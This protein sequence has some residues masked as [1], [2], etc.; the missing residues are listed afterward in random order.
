MA[1]MHMEVVSTHRRP[2]PRASRHIQIH[3]N[4]VAVNAERERTRPYP[5]TVIVR[6]HCPVH[7]SFPY[8]WRLLVAVD[9][10]R[11]A[12]ETRGYKNSNDPGEWSDT[13][14]SGGLAAALT[15]E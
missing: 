2:N 3:D 11:V 13:I 6:N 4:P 15:P 8:P 1:K 12:E 10:W 14:T 7:G 9:G 5:P